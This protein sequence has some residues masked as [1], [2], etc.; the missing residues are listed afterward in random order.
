MSE[1]HDPPSNRAT[2]LPTLLGG[3]ATL[4]F[5]FLLIPLT[6][7]FFFWVVLL[8]GAMIAL[9]MFHYL[10]WGK[11]LSDQVAG[12]REEIR[13]LEQ[14]RDDKKGQAGMYRR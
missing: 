12:E 5:L 3:L 1:P 14:A 7:G 10:L 9:G 2:F 11:T 6:G 13:L 8:T 4:F